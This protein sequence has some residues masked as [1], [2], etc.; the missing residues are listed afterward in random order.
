MAVR[1]ETE[2]EYAKLLFIKHNLD[3]KEI[4]TKVKVTEKTLGKW[5][6]DGK[7]REQKRSLLHT[8]NSVIRGLEEQMELWQEMIGKREDKL[9]SAKE[10]DLLIKLASGIKKLENEI[11]IGEIITANMGLIEFI[12][13]IDFDFSKKLTQYADLYINSK[14]K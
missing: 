13:S 14:M 7:W 2:K 10:A 1:K 9:A 6:N 12:Q 4:A 8:R 5:I 11:G 3:Q